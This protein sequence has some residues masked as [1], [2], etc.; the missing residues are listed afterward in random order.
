MAFD[1]IHFSV[2]V[3]SFAFIDRIKMQIVGMVIRIVNAGRLFSSLFSTLTTF[4]RSYPHRLHETKQNCEV[5]PRQYDYG[6]RDEFEVDAE[7]KARFSHR[8]RRERGTKNSSLEHFLSSPV[9][10]YSQ[11]R[12]VSLLNLKDTEEEISN[13]N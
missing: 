13:F 9:P 11:L 6:R 12:N 10:A 4:L 3:K 8:D 5:G 2:P 7:V 1:N